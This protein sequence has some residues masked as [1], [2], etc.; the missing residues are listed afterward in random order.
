M[1]GKRNRGEVTAELSEKVW[2]RLCRENALVA[3]E[4]WVDDARRVDFV[5]YRPHRPRDRSSNHATAAELESGTF[6]FVEVKSCMDDFTSGHGRTFEGD[7][8]WLVCPLELADSLASKGMLPKGAA[9]YSP[10]AR[11]ALR[12]RYDTSEFRQV[13]VAPAIELIWAML[14]RKSSCETGAYAREMEFFALDEAAVVGA[15]RELG[16]EEAAERDRIRAQAAA[17][18]QEAERHR[19]EA[20][21][22]FEYR[23]SCSPYSAMA[24]E[25]FHPELCERRVSKRRKQELVVYRLPDGSEPSGYAEMSVPADYADSSHVVPSVF[26]SGTGGDRAWR[27]IDFDEAERKFAAA[28]RRAAAFREGRPKLMQDE[29]RRAAIRETRHRVCTA[30]I[31]KS[32]KEIH[33]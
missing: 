2:A 27:D 7:E 17:R 12:K 6:T 24:Y 11:G 28:A 33:R 31:L 9:V 26:I 10:D 25:A 18:V 14:R 23:F 19:R 1:E 13:R 21:C 20:E 5:A 3:S 15:F 22:L 30:P 8:N 29:A 32:I 16:P 4:V